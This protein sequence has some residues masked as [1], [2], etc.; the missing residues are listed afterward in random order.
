MQWKYVDETDWNN[1]YEYGPTINDIYFP[2][3]EGTPSSTVSTYSHT[4]NNG[5]AGS[6]TVIL[7]K[8]FA[9]GTTIVLKAT[10]NEGYVFEGWYVEDECVSTELECEY[11]VSIHDADIEARYSFFSLTVTSNLSQM[12][13]AGTHTQ[14]RNQKVVPGTAV[15][16]V[17]TVNEGYNFD[18]WY[19]D[20]RCVSRNLSFT[21]TMDRFDAEIC[22]VYSTNTLTTLG[23]S[24]NAEGQFESTFAA[25]TY[26]KYTKQN[27]SAGEEVTLLATVNDGYN[28]VGWYIGEACVSTELEYTYVMGREDVEI[29]A[30]YVYY[31]LNTTVRYGSLGPGYTT[32][33]LFE[34]AGLYIDPVYK[35][36]RVS[37]GTEITV[38]AK[39]IVGWTF[40]GWISS[41]ETLLSYDLSFTFEMPAG[42]LDIFALYYNSNHV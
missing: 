35:D 34:S 4:D 20:D 15:E 36:K 24:A 2:V 3:P 1:L 26:T 39:D 19:I 30:V 33:D 13:A 9:V 22:A 5:L 28:F 18:G 6:Y 14:M 7:G 11:I 31:T 25:G 37:V 8:E 41:D 32:D 29:V 38:T 42:N 10:V 16:L 17:A 21:Y 12:G 40:V 27:V 23:A